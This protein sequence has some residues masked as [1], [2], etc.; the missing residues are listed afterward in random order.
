MANIDYARR[1]N[2]LQ[3]RKFDREFGTTI[4]SE[5]F[6]S[7]DIPNNIKYLI[8]AMRPIGKAYNNRTIEAA[9]MVKKHLDSGYDLHFNLAYRT[10]GSVTTGTN[11]RVH[12]DFDLLAII[13]R[14]FYPEVSNGNKYTLSDPHEDIFELRKQSTGTM[15]RTY[16]DVDTTGEKSISIF[17]KNLHRKVD[18]VFAYWY[19]S[20]IYQET[21]NEYYKG[22]YLYNFA[23]KEKIKDFPFATIHNVNYKG[24]NTADGSRMGIRLLKNMKADSETTIELSSFQLTSLVHSIDNS[25]LNYSL[26]GE[27]S[28]ARAISSEIYKLIND[29]SYRISVTCPNSIENPFEQESCVPQLQAL[30]ADLDL[31]IEDAISETKASPSVISLMRNYGNT[32]IV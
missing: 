23:N 20:K 3:N 28:I 5:S 32:I 12:S 10:Q 11:I 17:N 22:I 21:E 15:K 8:E 30:K 25:L 29:S 6:Q 14:Y 18:I 26:T 24:D 7:K 27:I 1:L 2:N 19:E 4:L 9:E 16:D 31:L 13:D